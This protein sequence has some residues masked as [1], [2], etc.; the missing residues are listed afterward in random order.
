MTRTRTHTNPLNIKHRFDSIKFTD[1]VPNDAK[2]ISLEIGFGRGVFLKHWATHN[3]NDFLLG[4]EVRKVIVTDVMS[5][6]KQLSLGNVALFHGS[7]HIFI[8]DVIPDNSLD[9]VF[10][11]HPDPWFKKRHHKRRVINLDFVKLIEAKLKKQGK[12][13]ISTDVELLWS[14]MCE[15]MKQF[16]L[17][18]IADDI[19]WKDIYKT[20]WD[21]FSKSDK[22]S[23]FFQAY[24]K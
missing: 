4:V 3:P 13:Y 8:E 21:L 19:F 9:H 10:V 18:E 14:D 15:V 17:T 6:V 7:G 16:S 22:R 12:L 1:I 20:H 24:Q 11:F 2:T 5:Q 23:I